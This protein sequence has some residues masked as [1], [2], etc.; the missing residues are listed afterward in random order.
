MTH[1]GT[2]L[3]GQISEAAGKLTGLIPGTPVVGGGGDQAAQA[4]G[5][6]AVVEPGIVA[7]TLGTSGVVFASS[8][9]PLVE[10]NGRLHAFPHA[11]PETWHV[12]GVMLSAAAGSLQWYRDVL[13]PGMG[14]EA[15]I[16][17]AADVEP[18]SEGLVFMP[19]LSGERTPHADPDIRGAFVG[20]TLRHGRPEMTRS[21]L[22]GGSLWYS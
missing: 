18:G 15:L 19:Y 16:E 8:D 12:M 21:V 10:K 9:Q 1:E 20:L 11:V 14:F 2:E 17:E 7:L 3:T 5:S 13:A 6:G 4:V 22:E